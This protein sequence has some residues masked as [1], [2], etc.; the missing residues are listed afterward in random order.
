MRTEAGMHQKSRNTGRAERRGRDVPRRRL[1]R[2][3]Q[4]TIE[5]SIV[6][7][8]LLLIIFA[9]IDYAQMFFYENALQNAMREATRFAT[10]GSVI[11]LTNG[12]V[13]QYTDYAGV[14][15]PKAINDAKGREASRY[16]CI[17]MFFQSNCVI[18]MATNSVQVVSASALPGAPPVLATNG[19]TGVIML[20]QSGGTAANDGP[21]NASDY[22]QLTATYNIH[23]I[24]PLFYLLGLNR[25]GTNMTV[26]PVRVSAVV[27]NEPALLNF[28]HNAEYPDEAP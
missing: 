19:S 13:P 14:S 15:V 11:Q 6:V 28:E 2:S 10:A 4:S 16:G 24:T 20:M 3:G 25:G 7:L 18:Q 23:T 1:R 21:G 27:K 26:F 22:V 8:V 17:R 5:F 12:G 9:I